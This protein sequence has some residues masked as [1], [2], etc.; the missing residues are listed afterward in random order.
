MNNNATIV[1]NNGLGD[2]LL[3]LIGFYVICKYLNYKPNV[4]FNDDNHW[5]SYDMKLFNLKDISS[6]IKRIDEL[7]EN[8]MKFLNGF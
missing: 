4:T 1:L 5:G 8:K 2:K 3:D 7:I 6:Y